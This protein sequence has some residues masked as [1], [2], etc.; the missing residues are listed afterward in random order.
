M[1]KI[2]IIFLLIS[3][4]SISS[5]GISQNLEIDGQI[6]IGEL[7]IDNSQGNFVV[8]KN[9]GTLGRRL[10]ASFQTKKYVIG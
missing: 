2:R 9:D 4:I 6:K 5:I 3:L 1:K 10:I 8:R 7:D